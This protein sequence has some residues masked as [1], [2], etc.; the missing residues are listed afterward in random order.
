MQAI[1]SVFSYC[2]FCSMV[3]Y[4]ARLVVTIESRILARC[5]LSAVPVS[6]PVVE[7]AEGEIMQDTGYCGGLFADDCT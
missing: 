1:Y 3:R 7:P 6:C 2:R 5:P 4:S